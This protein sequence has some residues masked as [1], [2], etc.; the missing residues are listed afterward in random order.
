MHEVGPDDGNYSL[1]DTRIAALR[2]ARSYCYESSKPTE[3][4]ST[5]V[6]WEAIGLKIDVNFRQLRGR[7]CPKDHIAE[8]GNLLPK[9][10]SLGRTVMACI[11][12]I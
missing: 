2:I 6:Y 12:S 3:F 5:G 8:L 9:V 4:G 7:V 1:F 11:A 10:H